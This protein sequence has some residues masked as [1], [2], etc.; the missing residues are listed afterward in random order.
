M[1][2]SFKDKI[3]QSEF[4]LTIISRD[5]LSLFPML[6]RAKFANLPQKVNNFGQNF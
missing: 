6:T 3:Y 5:H 1:L 2:E 4:V